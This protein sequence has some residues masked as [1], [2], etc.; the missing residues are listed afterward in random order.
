MSRIV[1][2]RRVIRRLVGSA[3]VLLVGVL[4]S[5]SVA[6]AAPYSDFGFNDINYWV[7]TGSNKAALVVDFAS[8]TGTSSY[9]WGYRWDGTA[10][11]EDMFTA[12]AGSTL[13]RERDGGP[14]A[15]TLTGSDR[16]LYLR[17]SGFGGG[18]GSSVFGIG[19]DA[20]GNGGSFTSGFEGAENGSAS[21]PGDLYAEGWFTGYWAYFV[22]ESTDTSW[23]YSGLGFSNRELTDG[24][25]D[26]WS[27]QRDF[28]GDVPVTPT[29]AAAGVPEP[30][31]ASLLI[32]GAV[33]ALFRRRRAAVL[34]AATAAVAGLAGGNALAA[35]PY[36]TSI[37]SQSGTGTFGGQSLYNDPAS[38]LGEPTRVAVN[39]D[40]LTGNAP[41]HVK[42]VEPA[43]NRDTAGNKV[44]TTLSRASDGAG[45]FNYG[46]ITV[47]FDQPIRD[48]P[49]NPYG[50]DLNVFGNTFYVGGG[51]TGGFVSDTTDLRNYYLAG[52]GFG[53]PVVVS[54]S[55][56]N[57][58]WYTYA[59]GPYGD[60]AFPTQGN[61]WSAAQHDATSNGWTDQ[62]TDFSKPVNPTLGTVLGTNNAA[63]PY[64]HT[65][66]ANGI[67]AYVG[68]GGGTGFDLAPSGFDAIQYVRVEA[69]A[70]F[71]DGEIDGFAAVQPT[72]VGD[73]LSVTPD[74]VSAGTPL[75]FQSPAD[76]DRTA[77]R[78]RFT[79]V[80]DLA[81]LAVT[82]LADPDKLSLI[83]GGQV[84][85]AY[86][87]TVSKL[88]GTGDVTFAANLDLL[89][90]LTYTGNGGDLK[91][92]S[93][94]GTGWTPRPFTFDPATG[95][96]TV[97][98]WSQADGFL[99][100]TQQV[101]EPAS[102]GVLGIAAAALLRR[103]RR[104]PQ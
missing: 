85:S 54:V 98:G 31:T 25:W 9:A 21:D 10:T 12:I 75:Y 2:R 73:A 32:V 80:G 19:Y 81:K 22:A 49:A 82:P 58:H 8:P 11:G 6:S 104:G 61:V 57:V 36:A 33:A 1:I 87:L 95:V 13:F 96:A 14:V 53:E 46:S 45:G 39:N 15:G 44:I 70:A 51:T 74:N 48:N 17:A 43:Y 4:G 59:S 101:P 23:G 26:G 5:A 27:F 97:T 89:A 79:S 78:A 100:V 72:K 67:N 18:L 103:S 20:N 62:K 38:V 16:R 76:P 65:S 77:V 50:V 37:V 64:Y 91:V 90:G 68:S 102:L 47:K 29:A 55:P 63:S 41:F 60:T 86:E 7:G 88:I 92:L 40:P 83:S 66:A 56:D 3:L 94:D 34:T 28:V 99:A 84:L 71:R 30:G 35:S 24:A 42:L 52:G 69:T 93:W